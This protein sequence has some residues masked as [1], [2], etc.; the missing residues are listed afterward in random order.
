[1]RRS[2][3]RHGGMRLT[4]VACDLQVFAAYFGVAP[5]CDVCAIGIEPNPRH[6]ARLREMQA[7]LTRADAP[8]AVLPA[9]AGVRD[10][11]LGFFVP[12]R[13]D[14]Y[15]DWGAAARPIPNYTRVEVLTYRCRIASP[16]SA[17]CRSIL[18]VLV[19]AAINPVPT[20]GG[21]A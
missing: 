12:A 1:M 16:H 18:D 13:P 9:A 4:C 21:G 6:A 19:A 2:M 17:C 3:R 15:V 11:A 5:R 20:I 7:R 8:L 14:G 10:G